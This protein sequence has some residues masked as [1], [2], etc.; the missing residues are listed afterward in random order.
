MGLPNSIW[1]GSKPNILRS[2][3]NFHVKYFVSQASLVQKKK[4]R[5]MCGAMRENSVPSLS[6]ERVHC[7]VLD[8]IAWGWVRTVRIVFCRLIVKCYSIG[9]R[10]D[11]RHVESWRPIYIET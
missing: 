3:Q 10:V 4:Y 11:M 9:W 7:C 2:A 5:Y 8:I 6:K 1:Q